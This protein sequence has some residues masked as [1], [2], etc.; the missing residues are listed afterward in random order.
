ARQ[1]FLDI[2]EGSFPRAEADDE[3]APYEARR[4]GVDTTRPA[5]LGERLTSGIDDVVYFGP[6]GDYLNAV[7]VTAGGGD[8]FDIQLVNLRSREIVPVQTIEAPG[9]EGVSFIAGPDVLD[10]K[11][12][13]AV[14]T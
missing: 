6:L 11:I 7:L 13:G 12:S 9:F 8:M 4:Y 1:D 5:R 2:S 14:L 3:D 10:F